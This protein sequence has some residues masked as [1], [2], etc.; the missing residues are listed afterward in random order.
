M[1]RERVQ[2]VAT[3]RLFTAVKLTIL[4]MVLLVGACDLLPRPPPPSSADYC[5]ITPRPAQPGD[6]VLTVWA[7]AARQH[8][9][10]LYTPVLAAKQV[11]GVSITAIEKNMNS[12]PYREH[13]RK[14]MED[15]QAPDIGYFS[16][17][18][19]LKF[20]DQGYLYPMENCNIRQ[21]VW[22]GGIAQLSE[23]GYPIEVDV[24]M[25]FYSK[26]ILEKLSWDKSSIEQF[27]QDIT[28]GTV[29]LN[30]ILNIARTAIDTGLAEKGFGFVFQEARFHAAM[31]FFKS[32]GGIF[33]SEM[34]QVDSNKRAFLETYRIYE[35]LRDGGI[36]HPAFS[37]PEFSNI[38]NRMSIRDAIAHGRI[39]FAYTSV[40]EWK[41]M[42]LDQNIEDESWLHEN[43][44][45]ALLPPVNRTDPGSAVTRHIGA[46]AILSEKATGK[47]N[48]ATACKIIRA[49]ESSNLHKQ[50]ATRTSQVAP[51]VNSVWSP[52]VLPSLSPTN[53]QQSL[54]HHPNFAA[55][56]EHV[57]NILSQL[58][59]AKITAEQAATLSA[60]LLQRSV[61]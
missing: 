60:R 34:Q 50:H 39:P 41:R 8:C 10:L 25:L 35:Q 45:I 20:A 57:V 49:I 5:D 58:A 11:D 21:T 46:Y 12:A 53:L 31:S 48:Q 37:Q 42:L 24:L 23:W 18:T 36:L 26:R 61:H 7:Y 40:S 19:L 47:N 6:V 27:P 44:G 28:K 16:H 4:P 59:N 43:I 22:N 51:T 9:L 32:N 17:G 2:S 15:R 14:V 55:F 3:I 38:Y 33:S 29:T 52:A 30:D 54:V 1:A 56:R 13:F